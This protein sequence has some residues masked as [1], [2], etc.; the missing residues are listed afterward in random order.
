MTRNSSAQ[1]IFKRVPATEVRAAVQFPNT[2][3][4]ADS[5]SK[6]HD[7]VKNEFRFVAMPDQTKL[8]YNFGDYSIYSENFAHH[9]EISMNY[10]RL[11]TTAYPGFNQFREMFWTALSQFAPCYRIGSFTSFA[12][13]Y[14]NQLPLTLEQN[15]EDCFTIDVVVPQNLEAPLAAGKSLLRFQQSEG[16][17]TVELDPQWSEKENRFTSY[18]VPLAFIC[19]KD[20]TFRKTG[21]ELTQLLDIGHDH[22]RRYFFS[23]LRESYIEYL[24]SL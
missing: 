4:V 14:F 23:I 10:F 19:Q 22:L 2:L 5:R 17:V 1:P 11:V 9:L 16:V 21:D 6:F 12:L 8:Q 24:K 3:E 18:N 15:F 20:V 7:L 13:Q